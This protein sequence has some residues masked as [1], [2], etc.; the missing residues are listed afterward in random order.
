MERRGCQQHGC[1]EICKAMDIIIEISHHV[2]NFKGRC[3]DTIDND[4]FLI[5]NDGV[6]AQTKDSFNFG[7]LFLSVHSL[8]AV[9]HRNVGCVHKRQRGITDTGGKNVLTC[10]LDVMVADSGDMS[11]HCALLIRSM[12][13]VHYFREASLTG[14]ISRQDAVANFDI[15]DSYHVTRF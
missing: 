4:K 14:R 3:D 11:E 12:R 8:N 7:H 15:R 13:Y 9:A 2:I 6:E 10:H 1:E 5:R